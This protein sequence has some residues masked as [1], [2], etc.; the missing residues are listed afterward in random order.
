MINPK[1]PLNPFS[2]SVEPD[3]APPSHYDGDS[4]DDG[5]DS[6]SVGDMVT[7]DRRETSSGD[8]LPQLR[9]LQSEDVEWKVPDS[10]VILAADARIRLWI[11]IARVVNAWYWVVHRCRARESRFVR[12][13]VKKSREQ[14]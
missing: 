11:H 3:S 10:L 2:I 9:E 8:T 7:I 6:L 1:L 14:F 5:T 12:L 13:M 4:D